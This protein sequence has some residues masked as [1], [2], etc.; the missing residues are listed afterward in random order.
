MN[1]NKMSIGFLGTDSN[2]K[3]KLPSIFD[4]CP[5]LQKFSSIFPVPL[6]PIISGSSDPEPTTPPADN[7][8][9]QDPLNDPLI[10]PYVFIF[11]FFFFRKYNFNFFYLL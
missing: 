10:T 6:K 3:P 1:E 5:E 2:K 9:S 8:V 4:T 11:S 7:L